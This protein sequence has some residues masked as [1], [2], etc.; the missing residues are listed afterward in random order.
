MMICKAD[1]EEL[2]PH[3]FAPREQPV[4][5]L[6]LKGDPKQA[7]AAPEEGPNVLARKLPSGEKPGAGAGQDRQAQHV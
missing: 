2:F 3:V 6:L 5:D 4:H 1:F 7:K